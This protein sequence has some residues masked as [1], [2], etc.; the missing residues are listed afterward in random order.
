MQIRFLIL[1]AADI[2]KFFYEEQ[3]LKQA[4]LELLSQGLERLN[5]VCRWPMFLW[6]MTV[7]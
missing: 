3:K 6:S 2:W 7:Q 5:Y 4:K 1:F